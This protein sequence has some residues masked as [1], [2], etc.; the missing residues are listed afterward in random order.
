MREV[1]ELQQP[2]WDHEERPADT[3]FAPS[4]VPSPGYLISQELP[5]S[6]SLLCAMAVASM[7]KPGFLLLAVKCIL[8]Y[9]LGG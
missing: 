4:Y 2:P 3:D 6:R 1:L 7:L 9:M 8:I 5:T